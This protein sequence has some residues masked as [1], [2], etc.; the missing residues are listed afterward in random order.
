MATKAPMIDPAATRASMTADH[1]FFLTMAYVIAAIIVAG[2]SLQVATGR[3][4]FAAPLLV[5]VHALIFFGWTTLYVV[6]NAL[7]AS[8]NVRLHRRLGWIGAGWAAAVVV[9]GIYTTATMV[10]RGASPFFF[11]P[12]FFLFMNALSVLAFG[13]LAA[14]AI[15]LRRRTEWHR[16][17][18][19]CGMAV[20]TGPAFGRLLP[21]PLLIPFAAWGVF[22]GVMLLPAIGIIGDLRRRGSVHPAWWWGI[23]VMSLTQIAMGVIAF[24]PAGLAVYDAVTTG[25]PGAAV[26]PLE[27]PQPPSGP[28]ITGR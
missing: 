8:G 26:A 27:F 25:A 1:R 4:T 12:V 2:F 24:S 10:R 19:F 14:A 5:H 15:V 6:Q 18:M 11:E 23:G 13:G 28:L 20:L 21:M 16:R 9:V 17:L 7:V 22:V 3:S